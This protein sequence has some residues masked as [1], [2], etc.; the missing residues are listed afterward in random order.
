[1]STLHACR[2]VSVKGRYCIRAIRGSPYPLRDI[3]VVLPLSI[4]RFYEFGAYP[5]KACTAFG[6]TL[7]NN[8]L[9]ILISLEF[10]QNALVSML[11]PSV[12]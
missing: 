1:M 8:D 7:E 4:V 3:P 5:R 9:G 6:D 2:L 11:S 12:G 10:D